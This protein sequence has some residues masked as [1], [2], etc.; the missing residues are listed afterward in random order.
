MAQRKIIHIDMDAFFASVEQLDAPALRGRPV[1]VGGDPAG[2]GV[3]AACSY[4]ARTFGIHSAMSCAGAYRLCPRA[5]FV[6]PRKERYSEISQQIMA[7]F[8]NYAELIEPLSLDEA[9]LD[10]TENIRGIPSATWTAHAI[11]Q[12]IY[13]QTG[14]TASA[15]VSCNKFLAKVAS[16]LNKP[17]GLTVITP[18]QAVP[19]VRRLPVRKFFGVGRVTEQRMLAMGIRQGAD[20]VRY[21]R[22]ELIEIFGKSGSFFYEIVR[23]I[24]CRPVRPRRGRKSVG[25]EVTFKEDLQCREQMLQ[26]LSQQA[27]RVE[28][29]LR[30][31]QLRGRTLVLKVRYHD[32]VTV[33]RSR[34]SGCLFC[35]TSDIMAQIPQLLAA[36][37]AGRKKVR[38]LGVTVTNFQ[39][40]Q[41][42]KRSF[43]QLPLPFP[44]PAGRPGEN[45]NVF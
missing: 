29:A 10:V 23:G 44:P 11:R 40:E 6:R 7:I 9:F 4:E 45:E 32:F 26:I 8:S 38:L 15:G 33:T 27:S 12:D 25:S 28:S 35:T 20:L 24:D 43:C 21:S 3:V 13:A 31:K 1:I 5:E 17:N 2:R 36:T 19:F 39:T 16:D 37:E 18:E 14:L 41:N 22:S 30:K 42:K 34:T